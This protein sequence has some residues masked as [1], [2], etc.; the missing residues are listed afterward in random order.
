MSLEDDAIEWDLGNFGERTYGKLG[1]LVS[2]SLFTDGGAIPVREADGC[3]ADR[4]Y[5]YVSSPSG[6][7]EVVV[8]AVVDVEAEALV[9]VS[10]VVV[11]ESTV[12][13]VVPTVDAPSLSTSVSL[14]HALAPTAMHSTATARNFAISPSCGRQMAWSGT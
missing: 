11:D 4:S 1:Q 8:V 10:G 2:V 5:R 13:T 6:A 7:G 12:L 9:V 14:V 3:F